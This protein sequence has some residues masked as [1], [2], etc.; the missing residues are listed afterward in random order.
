A[1]FN[2]IKI[3]G[4]RRRKGS[5]NMGKVIFWQRISRGGREAAR[6]WNNSEKNITIAAKRRASKCLAQIR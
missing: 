6:R 3:P 4:M 2:R 5:C 1:I